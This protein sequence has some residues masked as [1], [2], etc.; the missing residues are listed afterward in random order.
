M[1][2]PFLRSATRVAFA[3]LFGTLGLWIGPPDGRA[4][5]SAIYSDGLQN[6]WQ[7]WSWATVDIGATEPVSTGVHSIQVDAGGWEAVYFRH[8]Q[9]PVAGYQAIQLRLH[10]GSAGGQ[11]L[12]VQAV[13]GNNGIG[14]AVNLPALAVGG[15]TVVTVPLT[16]MNSPAVID[17]IWLQNRTAGTL[18]HF[19]ADEVVL[20]RDYPGWAVG[21]IPDAALRGPGVDADHDGAAN[22]LEWGMGSDP[23]SPASVPSYRFVAVEGS[24]GQQYPAIQYEHPLTRAAVPIGVERSGDLSIWATGPSQ[25]ALADDVVDLATGLRRVTVRSTTPLSERRS[26]H[27]RLVIP[28]E[29]AAPGPLALAMPFPAASSTMIAY[30]PAGSPP[31]PPPS[32]VDVSAYPPHAVLPIF[33]ETIPGLPRVTGRI[34]V[35]QFGYLPDLAKVAV[36]SDPQAG[37]NAHESYEPGATLQ[38]RRRSDGAV[39]FSAA[40]TLWNGG[41]THEDSGDRGWW[42]DFSSVTTPGEYYIYD[43]ANERRSPVFRIG[44]EVYRDVLRAAVRTFYYQRLAVPLEEPYAEPPWT[45]A[46]GFPQ[47]AWARDVNAKNDPATARDL[48]GGWMDAGDSNKYPSFLAEVIHPLLY[49]WRAHPGAFGDDFG[50]PESGNGLPDLLDEIKFEL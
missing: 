5:S 20:L 25:L 31:P 32:E 8:N 13:L 23:A 29:A 9:F 46:P 22:L 35:D 49:A 30:P 4:A 26:D 16:A 21:A 47:D 15:W 45:D 48:A 7:N 10:G 3:F 44:D 14:T 12:R 27:F 33:G 24:D 36:I 1:T 42:F 43:P 41:A 39:V 28:T 11:L 19:F 6:G 38:V 17:G 2:S 50:I 34:H 37:Y 40:P 18:P